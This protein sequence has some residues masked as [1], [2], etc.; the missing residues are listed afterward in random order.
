MYAN[1][2]TKKNKSNDKQYNDKQYNDNNAQIKYQFGSYRSRGLRTRFGYTLTSLGERAFDSGSGP[3]HGVSF[4]CS[5]SA[6][7][8]SGELSW[9]GS[10]VTCSLA[11]GTVTTGESATSGAKI[12]SHTYN[13]LGPHDTDKFDHHAILHREIPVLISPELHQQATYYQC[14]NF[15]RKLDHQFQMN[16]HENVYCDAS[17]VL[18]VGST[19]S[20]VFGFNRSKRD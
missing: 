5:D 18:L 20:A 2:I 3:G 4:D 10:I 8:V 12:H 16:D 17:L 15:E 13:E 9:M 1:S 11:T 14:D 7:P 6:T 19:R